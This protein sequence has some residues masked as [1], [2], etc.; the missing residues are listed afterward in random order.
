[1]AEPKKRQ[2]RSRSNKRRS[3]L[4]LKPTAPALCSHCRQPKIAHRVCG[5]C[6]HYAGAEVFVPED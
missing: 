1:M 2:T 4:A 3:H 6:G 5:N